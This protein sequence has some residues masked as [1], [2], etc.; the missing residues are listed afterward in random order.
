VNTDLADAEGHPSFRDSA[1]NSGRDSQFMNRLLDT[2]DQY[3]D[4]C[5]LSVESLCS[6]MNMSQTMLY[7]KLK[8]YTGLSITS[9][10]RKVR[11]KKAAQMLMQSSLS[12]SE[13]AYRVGFN[14]PGYFSRCFREE[15]GLSPRDFQKNSG[16][17]NPS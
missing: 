9:F 16:P 14:D 7:R 10:I 4:D 17:V 8:A 1:G 6:I 15:F 5:D 3:I 12:V 13:V 11:L 2:I